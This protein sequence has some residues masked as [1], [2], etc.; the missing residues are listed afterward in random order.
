MSD[1]DSWVSYVVSNSSDSYTPSSSNQ[2]PFSLSGLRQENKASDEQVIWK[3]LMPL[4]SAEPA[5]Y[6][7]SEATSTSTHC[8]PM[9]FVVDFDTAF[10]FDHSGDFFNE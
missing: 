1:S 10:C 3:D 4:N 2:H 8:L 5:V 6:S 7:C 9:D